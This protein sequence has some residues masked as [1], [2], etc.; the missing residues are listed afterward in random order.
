VGSL[1]LVWN[2]CVEKELNCKTKARYLGLMA[3]I[4]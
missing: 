4:H 2:S 3:V 1:M